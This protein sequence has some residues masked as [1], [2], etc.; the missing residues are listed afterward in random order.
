MKTQHMTYISQLTPQLGKFLG[1]ITPRW[2]AENCTAP[3]TAAAFYDG[4]YVALSE[5]GG[6]AWIVSSSS[7][8][9]APRLVDER[10][11]ADLCKKSPKELAEYLVYKEAE[12]VDYGFYILSED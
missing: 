7:D 1:Y 5:H 11:L 10:E 9:P 8:Y 4:D 2:I 3:G 6:S 12:Q